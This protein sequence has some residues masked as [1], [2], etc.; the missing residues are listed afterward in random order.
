MN[1][2]VTN[3]AVMYGSMQLAQ[4]IPFDDQPEYVAYARTGYVVAQLACIAV[5]YY[6]SIQVKKKND[7][8]VLKY[9]DAKKPMVRLC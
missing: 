2:A 5:Y 3:M 1:A 8:T 9:V 4:R 7:L 6:C